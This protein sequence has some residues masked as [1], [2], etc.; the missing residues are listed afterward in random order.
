[1]T[2]YKKQFKTMIEENQF[3][4]NDFKKHHD[5]VASGD[6]S[7]RGDFEAKGQKVLRVIRRY[8]DSLCA[9]SENSGFGKFSEN[10]SE[11]FWEEV[12]AYLPQI[13]EVPLQ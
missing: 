2:K 1:M 12:R 8:E 4:F 11:K 13:D 5:A 3:L 9:K 7:A 6:D 10:L